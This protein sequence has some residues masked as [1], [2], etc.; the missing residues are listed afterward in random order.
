MEQS[1]PNERQI[2][3]TILWAL[4]IYVWDDYELTGPQGSIVVTLS[5]FSKVEIR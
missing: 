5:L 1:P 2:I 3:K 4:L